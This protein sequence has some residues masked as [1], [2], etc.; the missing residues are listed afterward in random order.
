MS[1]RDDIARGRYFGAVIKVAQLGCCGLVFLSALFSRQRRT[2]HDHMSGTRVVPA[3][4]G[5]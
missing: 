5:R 4:A 1:E 3:D 2:L